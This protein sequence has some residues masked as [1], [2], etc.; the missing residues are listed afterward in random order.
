MNKSFSYL[1]VLFALFFV[2][3]VWGNLP[4]HPI[5]QQI[6]VISAEFGLFNPPESGKPIFIPTRSVPFVENQV[7][8]WIIVIK[9]NKPKIKWREEFTLPS[10]PITWGG[11]ET[12]GLN[13]ISHDRKT[14]VIER[15]IKLD[16]GLISNRWTI[17]PGDPKGRYVIH[18]II[19]GIMERTFEFDVQ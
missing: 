2:T 17:A 14:S 7:Y 12:Q 15:E 6:E 8:G 9:T 16:R 13:T 1:I 11:S 4:G 10:S 19:D 18:V 3:E 5:G